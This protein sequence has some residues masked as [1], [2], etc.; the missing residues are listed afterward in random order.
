[1]NLSMFIL[2]GYK[3]GEKTTAQVTSDLLLKH[4]I[5]EISLKISEV[6]TLMHIIHVCT[7]RRSQLCDV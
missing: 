4:E 1:M 6:V 7:S 2:K 3:T 5:S